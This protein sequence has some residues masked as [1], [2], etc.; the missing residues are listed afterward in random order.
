MKAY[1]GEHATAGNDWLFKKL[2]RID[3]DNSV[4]WTLQMLKGR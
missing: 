2:P 3:E 1:F 4:Y